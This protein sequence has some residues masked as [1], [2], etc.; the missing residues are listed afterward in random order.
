MADFAE[1]SLCEEQKAFA[2]GG[3]TGTY[4][5]PLKGTSE[6]LRRFVWDHPG[7]SIR[8]A[9]EHIETHY[10]SKESAKAHLLRLAREG[11]IPGVRVSGLTRGKRT[12]YYLQPDPE[13]INKD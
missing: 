3:S 13:P 10:A 12:L 8:Q 9:V 2:Q 6:K 4:W 7:C 5:T 1:G 11:V